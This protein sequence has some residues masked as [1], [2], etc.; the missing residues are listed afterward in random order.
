[1]LD[2]NNVGK[3]TIKE[4]QF[5]YQIKPSYFIMRVFI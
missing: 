3:I 2:N 1:M 4:E 5:K